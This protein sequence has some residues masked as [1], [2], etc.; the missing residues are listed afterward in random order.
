[1]FYTEAPTESLVFA[2]PK[3]AEYNSAIHHALEATTWGEFKALIPPEEYKQLLKRLQDGEYDL[4]DDEDHDAHKQRKLPSNNDPFDPDFWFPGFCE[5][6]YPD[7]LQT[8]DS[9]NSRINSAPANHITAAFDLRDSRHAPPY[10]PISYANSPV[11]WRGP[12]KPWMPLKQH[13]PWRRRRGAG[14]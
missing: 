7:W 2:P 12:W 9:A 4:D 8:Q 5:G 14:Q 6:D 13:E 11:A 3:V 1:L 10:Q